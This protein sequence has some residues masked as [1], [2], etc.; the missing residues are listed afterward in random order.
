MPNPSDLHQI[1]LIRK[2]DGMYKITLMNAKET[3]L[4]YERSLE[5]SALGVISNFIRLLVAAQP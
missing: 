2:P 4:V 1:V 3:V 5:D